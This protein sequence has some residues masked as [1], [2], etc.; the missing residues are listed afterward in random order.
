MQYMAAIGHV[1]TLVD[2][3]DERAWMDDGRAKLRVW[4][5]CV[6]SFLFPFAMHKANWKQLPGA[7]RTVSCHGKSV[8]WGTNA[9]HDIYRWDGSTWHQVPG[10]LVQL[11]ISPDGSKVWGVNAADEIFHSPVNAPGM[12]RFCYALKGQTQLFSQDRGLKLMENWSASPQVTDWSGASIAQIR[13]TCAATAGLGNKSR[14][15]WSMFHA[16]TTARLSGVSTAPTRSSVVLVM[17]G[18]RLMVLFDSWP[19]LLMAPGWLAS[20]Q[21]VHFKRTELWT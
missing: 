5:V 3:G 7:L 12:W 14:V 8:V 16:T 2:G 10:K 11:D 6:G 13:F 9:G 18:I 15:H 4:I 20:M 17:P 21:Y 1:M 19:F